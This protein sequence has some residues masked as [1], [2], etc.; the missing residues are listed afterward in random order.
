MDTWLIIVSVAGENIV[1]IDSKKLG[2]FDLTCPDF[3]FDELKLPEEV[4]QILG[5]ILAKSK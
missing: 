1:R 2:N 4:K 5:K 3:K